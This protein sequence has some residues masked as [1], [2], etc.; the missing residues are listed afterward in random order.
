VAFVGARAGGALEFY[1][2]PE[3][4]RLP[5]AEY[6]RLAAECEAGPFVRDSAIDAVVISGLKIAS[7][8]LLPLEDGGCIGLCASQA[9][10]YSRQLD[11]LVII[12]QIHARAAHRGGR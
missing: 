9:E 7:R 6:Q 8:V 10:V 1:T 5:H 4:A 11:F 3:G 12:S 2:H